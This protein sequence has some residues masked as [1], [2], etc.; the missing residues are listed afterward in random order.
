MVTK[1]PRFALAA[2]LIAFSASFVVQSQYPSVSRMLIRT[3]ETSYSS[4]DSAETLGGGGINI[5]GIDITKQ[6]TLGNT[7]IALALS[8]QSAAEVVD[9]IGVEKINGVKNR[10]SR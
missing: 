10:A 2:G 1:R 9:R 8:K 6:Q 5:G 4:T 3:G 7:L